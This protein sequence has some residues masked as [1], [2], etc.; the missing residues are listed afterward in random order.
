MEKINLNKKIQIMCNIPKYIVL[1][2][3]K[4]KN[5]ILLNKLGINISLNISN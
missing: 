5:Y 1:N 2:L 4:Y 3:L